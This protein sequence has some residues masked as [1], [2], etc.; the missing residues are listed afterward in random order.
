MYELEAVVSHLLRLRCPRRAFR[1]DFWRT[2][3]SAFHV[4]EAEYSS[5]MIRR[6]VPP[7]L[8][9]PRMFHLLSYC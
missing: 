3:T 1:R 5:T 4:S 7:V 2:R 6:Y 8:S 9:F